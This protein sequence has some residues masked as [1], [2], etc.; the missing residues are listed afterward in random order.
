MHV[1]LAHQ[2]KALV[3][4]G[5]GAGLLQVFGQQIRVHLRLQRGDAFEGINVFGG[6]GVEGKGAKHNHLGPG[7]QVCGF[8]QR[9]LYLPLLQCPMLGAE[10][11]D[12]PLARIEVPTGVQAGGAGQDFELGKL[13]HL[14]ALAANAGFQ[15]F[16]APLVLARGFT[17][18]CD[19]RIGRKI[20]VL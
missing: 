17:R 18:A 4:G 9:V 10:A 6:F 14:A 16:I 2:P 5:F 19:R 7:E 3:G 15:Q 13:E 8:A 11:D 12:Y 1:G 20:A